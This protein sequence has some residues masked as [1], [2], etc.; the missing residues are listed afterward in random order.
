MSRR[1]FTQSG[2]FEV[3]RRPYEPIH[4]IHVASG[5]AFGTFSHLR[6]RTFRHA[7]EG[8]EAAEA[9]LSPEQ[10]AAIDGQASAEVWREAGKALQA[11]MLQQFPNGAWSRG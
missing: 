11:A 1:H 3:I 5:L 7:L 8:I 9:Q 10:W 2:R 6:V 4:A